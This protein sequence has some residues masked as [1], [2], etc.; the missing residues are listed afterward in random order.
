MS[1]KKD[2]TIVCSLSVAGIFL[3]LFFEASNGG[4]RANR[5][6]SCVEDLAQTGNLEFEEIKEVCSEYLKD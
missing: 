2:L 4:L 6:T 1:I 3:I 5:Y